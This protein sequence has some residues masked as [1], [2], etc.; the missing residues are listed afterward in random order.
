[1]PEAAIL[2][3]LFQYY[4]VKINVV[5][6]KEK[7]LKI[8]PPFLLFLACSHFVFS[9]GSLDPILVEDH[10]RTISAKLGEDWLITFKE[11]DF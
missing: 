6:S 4:L 8:N 1:M 2:A 3:G 10:P 11:E 7:I 5:V 9:S